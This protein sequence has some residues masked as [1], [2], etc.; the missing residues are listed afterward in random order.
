MTFQNGM[1]PCSSA[2]RTNCAMFVCGFGTPHV[3]VS[4]GGCNSPALRVKRT[5]KRLTVG[6]AAWRYIGAAHRREDHLATAATR[7]WQF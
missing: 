5:A 6:A 3:T 1:F 4:D 2:P 7:H